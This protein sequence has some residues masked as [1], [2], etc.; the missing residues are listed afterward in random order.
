MSLAIIIIA[1]VV[2]EF[3]QIFLI[4]AWAFTYKSSWLSSTYQYLYIQVL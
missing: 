3:Q 1:V 4:L 2:L